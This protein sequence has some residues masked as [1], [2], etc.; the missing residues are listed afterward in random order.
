MSD[1][2]LNCLVG[3]MFDEQCLL[4]SNAKD[5]SICL[6]L[7]SPKVP[8]ASNTR[9]QLKIREAAADASA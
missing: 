4:T 5:G 8:I 3:N 2:K 9:G 6:R 1:S 7:S